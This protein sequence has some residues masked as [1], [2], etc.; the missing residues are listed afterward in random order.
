MNIAIVAPRPDVAVL[1]RAIGLNPEHR[2][3]WTT[4]NGAEAARKCVSN[5]PD[6]VLL[7]GTLEDMDGAEA[8]RRIVAETR[9]VI[10]VVSRNPRGETA[11]IVAA[12]GQGAFDAADMPVFEGSAS[13]SSAASLL[14]KIAAISRMN[15]GNGMRSIQRPR[16]VLNSTRHDPGPLV[17]IGASAGGPA[18]LATIL[19]ELPR[20]FPAAVV[21]VQ[22]VDEHVAPGMADWL[23][24]HC[25]LPARV[26]VEGDRPV[27]GTVLLAGTNDHLILKT[28]VA[29]GYTDE[30][31]DNVYRPSV[32]VFFHS[33]SRLW[34]GEAVGV[35][36]TGMGRDGALGLKALR[37][38][39]RY[40]IAQD[41]T[42][43]AVY[44]MPK[45]ARLAG[46]A[47]DVLPVTAI[48]ARLVERFRGTH[49]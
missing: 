20:E 27:A 31:R 5:P 11:K 40:T 32:D 26:A 15:D 7:S 19:S 38:Q 48:A 13:S 45:A 35:V 3:L 25:S 1:D 6:L 24:G 46:A 42:S 2:V 49:R 37:D 12:M 8:T 4:G 14:E 23:A 36:L 29:L 9:C 22:H 30:P 18:A 41:E 10:L 28:P 44:G 21:V 39:G 16:G 47:V 33:V 17:A 34:H 43:S